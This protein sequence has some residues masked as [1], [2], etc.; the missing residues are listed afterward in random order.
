MKLLKISV[1][2]VFWLMIG[3]SPGEK[4]MAQV[5]PEVKLLAMP[6]PVLNPEVEFLTR[7]PVIDGKLDTGLQGLVHRPF[8][9]LVKMNP[10]NPDT[11]AG[12]RLAYGTDFLYLFIELETD[13]LIYRDRNCPVEIA[14][15]LVTLM[16]KNGIR[17]FY[18]L[19][20]E[21]GH[22]PPKDPAVIS[23]YRQWLG[24]AIREKK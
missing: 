8:A 5:E 14:T 22:E 18:L 4:V 19:D 9:F 16:K 2:A 15:D 6:Q 3:I 7:E 13:K 21:A 12:Y 23:Q 1:L 20:P 24:K 10:A 11:G 17:L